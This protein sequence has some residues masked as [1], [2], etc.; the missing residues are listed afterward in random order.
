MLNRQGRKERQGFIE[1]IPNSGKLI[2]LFLI[3]NPM[4]FSWRPWRTWRFKNRYDQ[5]N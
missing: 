5:D 2:G 1:I 4:R 3:I